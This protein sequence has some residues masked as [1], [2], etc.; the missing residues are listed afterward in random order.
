M[1][2]TAVYYWDLKVVFKELIHFNSSRYGA[3]S[4]R[5]VMLILK[6]SGGRVRVPAAHH[7]G[8]VV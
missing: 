8:R 5:H 1:V 2:R 6:G 4:Y 7:C 3:I